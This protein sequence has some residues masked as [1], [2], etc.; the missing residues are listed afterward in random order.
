MFDFV[1][2]LV[3]QTL[4]LSVYTHHSNSIVYE[5]WT[6]PPCNFSFYC[7]VSVAVNQ[8]KR[9]LYGKGV[10]KQIC[11]VLNYFAVYAH[12]WYF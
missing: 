9:F 2:S 1:K 4:V 10:S 12:D 5:I 3:L 11:D 8:E 7:Y 6:S